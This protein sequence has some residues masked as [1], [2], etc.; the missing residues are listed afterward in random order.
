MGTIGCYYIIMTLG[1]SLIYN[2]ILRHTTIRKF[3]THYKDNFL[4]WHFAIV[5]IQHND[6]S[7]QGRFATLQFY[8]VTFRHIT[9]HHVHQHHHAVTHRVHHAQHSPWS[10]LTMLTP[11]HAHNPT[12]SPLITYKC[13]THHIYHSPCSPLK[14]TA[15]WQYTTNYCCMKNVVFAL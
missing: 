11:H 10:P 5:T 8:T 15:N 12:C 9:I 4:Q 13:K 14:G 6:I 1:A 3:T 2:S 7:L